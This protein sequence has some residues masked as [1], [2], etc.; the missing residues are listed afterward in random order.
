MLLFVSKHR[1]V[2][3]V[4]FFFFKLLVEHFKLYAKNFPSHFSGYVHNQFNAFR[5]WLDRHT[6][7]TSQVPPW[8]SEMIKKYFTMPHPFGLKK[9]TK[10]RLTQCFDLDGLKWVIRRYVSAPQHGTLR[11]GLLKTADAA[12]VKKPDNVITT[13]R[14]HN[15]CCIPYFVFFCCFLF[16]CVCVQY[17]SDD[18]DVVDG[19]D[20]QP[21]EEHDGEDKDFEAPVTNV[22]NKA[23]GSRKRKAGG[24]DVVVTA[25]NKKARSTMV[26]I[27][28]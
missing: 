18:E 9:E 28:C 4:L 6:E 7:Q 23:A 8:G 27:K 20:A 22:G 24:N 12:L 16:F 10:N 2:S 13:K 5:R 3:L 17:Q 21:R 15:F 19:D 25:G 11:I 1:I 14:L 26:T